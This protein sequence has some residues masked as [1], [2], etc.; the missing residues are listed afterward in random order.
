VF[1]ELP[2]IVFPGGLGVE[3]RACRAM[4]EVFQDSI[5]RQRTFRGTLSSAQYQ[6]V[7]LYEYNFYPFL[8]CLFYEIQRWG[9][10]QKSNLKKT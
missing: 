3:R 9:A 1:S 4:G 6:Q 7:L 5:E 2:P 8:R 10:Y